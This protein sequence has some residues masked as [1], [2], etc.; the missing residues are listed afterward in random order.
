MNKPYEAAREVDRERGFGSDG[1][2]DVL[3]GF[4]EEVRL[5]E[6]EMDAYGAMGMGRE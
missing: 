3:E 2:A 6:A 5:E 4:A 1:P